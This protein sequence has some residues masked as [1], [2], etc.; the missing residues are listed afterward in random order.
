[1]GRRV[2]SHSIF[3][4][5]SNWPFIIDSLPFRV[6]HTGIAHTHTHTHTHTHEIDAFRNR[7]RN[8]RTRDKKRE[9]NRWRHSGHSSHFTHAWASYVKELQVEARRKEEERFQ[10]AGNDDHV[11]ARHLVPRRDA[12]HALARSIPVSVF[13]FIMLS[14][15]VDWLIWF[16]PPLARGA[17]AWE[18]FD[19]L[20][21]VILWFDS[22]FHK[23]AGLQQL[24]FESRWIE[25]AVAGRSSGMLWGC[26][27]DSLACSNYASIVFVWGDCVVYWI[28]ETQTDWLIDGFRPA[29]RLPNA[30]TSSPHP[31]GISPTPS[32]G[33][34]QVSSTSPPSTTNSSSSSSS[35]SSSIWSS[36]ETIRFS[37]I[38]Q[39]Y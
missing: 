19:F 17:R 12:S 15:L 24:S 6:V 1:M 37:Q 30:A 20:P 18:P 35:S 7:K 39:H 8:E 21:D 2:V 26:L 4:P 13:G 5:D 9:K 25:W 32:T 27:R 29:A 11:P 31:T 28:R 10:V 23:S 33:P 22:D 14:C 36:S 34:R 38:Y 3:H 16:P